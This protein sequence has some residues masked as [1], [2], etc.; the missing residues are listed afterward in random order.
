MPSL[1][2]WIGAFILILTTVSYFIDQPQR[3]VPGAALAFVWL[4]AGQLAATIETAEKT[5]AWRRHSAPP[6]ASLD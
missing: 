4:I 5:G 6:D 3:V 2:R 1:C